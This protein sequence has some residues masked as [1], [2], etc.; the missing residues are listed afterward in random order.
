MNIEKATV[1]YEKHLQRVRKYNEENR[2]KINEAMKSNYKKIKNDEQK[3]KEYLEKKRTQYHT[4]KQ[5]KLD[6][7][8]ISKN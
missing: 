7:P 4:K 6:D 8:N 1:F 5:L 3:Y 2:D